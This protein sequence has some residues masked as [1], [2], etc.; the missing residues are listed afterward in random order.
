MIGYPNGRPQNRPLVINVLRF[1]SDASP[2]EVLS[3]MLSAEHDPVMGE[4]AILS[5]A[6]AEILQNEQRIANAIA[7]FVTKN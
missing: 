3:Q 7:D 6:G 4:T 5:K 2:P 1:T